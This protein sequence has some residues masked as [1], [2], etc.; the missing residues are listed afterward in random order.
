MFYS[1]KSIVLWDDYDKKYKAGV[2]RYCYP[3]GDASQSLGNIYDPDDYYVMWRISPA[4]RMGI[5][6]LDRFT[7][8]MQKHNLL[9]ITSVLS[10]IELMFP[11]K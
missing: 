11:S 1:T 6:I 5:E 10:F 2:I 9:R 3:K 4:V 7:K 8:P